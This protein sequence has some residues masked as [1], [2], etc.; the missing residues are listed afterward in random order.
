MN[1]EN[2]TQVGWVL[3]NTA[4]R[5]KNFPIKALK[6]WKCVFLFLFLYILGM[7]FQ[8]T[9][10][11][12]TEAHKC[13][14]TAFLLIYLSSFRHV[15]LTRFLLFLFTFSA[16]FKH[17]FEYG[18]I[19]VCLSP[20]LSLSPVWSIQSLL[21]SAWQSSQ[22]TVSTGLDYLYSSGGISLI[23]SSLLL[24]ISTLFDW[25]NLYNR[26]KS[27]ISSKPVPRHQAL[28]WC[29]KFIPAFVLIIPS[30]RG[31]EWIWWAKTKLLI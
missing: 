18:L 16:Y 30:N 4:D 24:S 11:L 17:L 22:I 26:R 31:T 6:L 14:Q 10:K 13:T 3:W 29:L 1:H 25:L 20:L 2:T 21:F 23:P 28:L 8:I 12:L 19:F 27:Y 9:L 7:L 15:F 5:S